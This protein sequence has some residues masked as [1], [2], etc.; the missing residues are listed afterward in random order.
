MKKLEAKMQKEDQFDGAWVLRDAL[1][2]YIAHR[3]DNDLL[4]TEWKHYYF[5]TQVGQ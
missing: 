5:I 3:Q 1:G 2:Q 4:W